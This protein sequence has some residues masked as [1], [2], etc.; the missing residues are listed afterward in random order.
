[1]S[2]ARRTLGA[3]AHAAGDAVV[4]HDVECASYA[5]DLDLW[6]RLAAERGGAVLDVGCGTGRVALA[7]AAEGHAVTGLEVEPALLD[8]LAARAREA[9][10]RVHAQAGDVRA[11]D[12]GRA[13]ALGIAPMQVIQLLH[14]RDGRRAALSAVRRHLEPGGLF[15]VALADPFEGLPASEALPPLPDVRERDGWVWSSMPVAVREAEGDGAGERRAVVERLRQAVSP[16]GELFEALATV[17]LDLFPPEQLE[18]D[19]S[20]AGFRVLERERVPETES[21]VS[22]VVVM[23]EAA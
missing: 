16:S 10:V 6:R 11:F 8:A 23:L 1:V 14:G 7:L 18:H 2:A 20:R 9:G 15:A 12:L 5:A 13:F 3:P 19:A 4:W 22:S 17:H 21:Y